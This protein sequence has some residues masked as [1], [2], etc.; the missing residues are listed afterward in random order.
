MDKWKQ[1]RS[2]LS[3]WLRIVSS[4]LFLAGCTR[5][6]FSQQDESI[7]RQH[8]E[9]AH[10]AQES[11]AL[12]TAVREYKQVL[13]LQ[14]DIAEVYVNLGLVYYAQNKFADSAE[15]LT[16]ADTL[17]P[18]LRGVSLYLG[19]DDVKLNL[20]SKAIGRLQEAVRL[21]PG[22]KEANTWLGTALWD[23]GKTVA[24]LTQL[25]QTSRLFPSDVDSLFLL[26]EAYRK[27]GDQEVQHVLA[28]A[29]GTALFHQIYGDIYSRQHQWMKAATHYQ[30]AIQLDPRSAGA[31]FGL[32][33]VYLRQ[34]KLAE[35]AREFS[36]ALTIAPASVAPQARLAE[37]DLLQDKP[38][39]ALQ[40]L[41]RAVRVSPERTANAL[42]LQAI[43]MAGNELYDQT[44]QAEIQKPLLALQVASPSPAKSLAMAMADERLGRQDACLAEWM[45]F[46]KSWSRPRP[47]ASI[48][49]RAVL[50][51][52][53]QEFAPAEADLQAS[54]RAHPENLQAQYLLGKTYRQ[55]STQVAEH[56]LA[57]DPNSIRVHQLVAKTYENSGEDDKALN[58]YR[59]V[60][61]MDPTLPG[62][63][64][65]IGHLLWKNEQPDK[66][67]AELE[68][69]VALNPDHA[70]AN[71]E[72]GTILVSQHQPDQAL[73]Y[74]KKA[75][76]LA[77]D[78][79]LLHQ[80]LGEAYFMN[81]DYPKAESELLIA[82]RYD[83]DGGAHYLLGSVYRGEG[84]P[85]D[86]QKEFEVSKKLKSDK[87]AAERRNEVKLAAAQGL[88]E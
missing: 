54:V 20:P 37:V 68:E 16:R 55:L 44:M 73:P 57:L 39:E 26:A 67:L 87:L 32:G 9:A 47:T 24:A 5:V 11:G 51:F 53:R 50:E 19:I 35:A 4:L 28:G 25:Q 88:N 7:V 18:G 33:V 21:E 40:V 22:S 66:A 6:L 2:P 31:Y 49:Q 27:A 41:A 36:R 78:L 72:I 8:F 65:A 69:E 82:I 64:F 86:A 84:R 76:E 3:F 70:E 46:K 43:S 1:I 77:P 23:A 75:I 56:M 58:E 34:N 45:N 29:S 42:N 48:Y 60:A 15:A 74:L 85:Q 62:V 30:R 17:K 52:D 38:E 81:K 63:H 83:Q 14:P 13:L 59:L 79:S 71:A 10:Q 12:D 80:Q 61:K